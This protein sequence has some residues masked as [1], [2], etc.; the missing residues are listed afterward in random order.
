VSL[1]VVSVVVRV[2][3][4]VLVF[5]VAELLLKGVLADVVITVVVWVLAMHGHIV[6]C[7]LAHVSGGHTE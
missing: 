1:E 5:A 4:A 6:V 3:T 7:G 2:E